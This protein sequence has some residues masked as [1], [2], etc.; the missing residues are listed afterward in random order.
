MYKYKKTIIIN[1]RKRRIFSKEKSNTEYILYKNDYIT[2]NAYNKKTGGNLTKN[3]LLNPFNTA[4]RFLKGEK[5]EFEIPNAYIQECSIYDDKMN[6]IGIGTYNKINSKIIFDY[7]ISKSLI[8]SNTDKTHW[9]I[10]EYNENNENNMKVKGFTENGWKLIEYGKRKHLENIYNFYTKVYNNNNIKQNNL[11]KDAISSFN[12]IYLGINTDTDTDNILCFDNF[13]SL[14]NIKEYDKLITQ[15]YYIY[16]ILENLTNL[17]VPDNY[18]IGPLYNNIYT[19][20]EY[21][22][23]HKNTRFMCIKIIPTNKDPKLF[24]VSF[25][26]ISS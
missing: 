15:N 3:N 12:N 6:K 2:L 22:K 14:D 25:K 1:N 17:T 23:I 9:I 8:N 26:Y 16:Y 11:P 4:K 5:D 19:I 21:Y 20:G 18:I 24:T 10:T 13:F 7:L